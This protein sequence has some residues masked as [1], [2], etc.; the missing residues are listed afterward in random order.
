MKKIL[1]SAIAVSAFIAFASSTETRS[2]GH[3]PI[4][5]VNKTIL[6]DTIP[7]KKSPTKKP[8]NPTRKKNPTD[9]TRVLPHDT[10]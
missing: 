6:T 4:Y 3:D 5:S 8:M 2:S 1:L 10:M 7:N 9:S